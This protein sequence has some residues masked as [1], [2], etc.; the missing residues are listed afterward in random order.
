MVVSPVY[1]AVLSILLWST[2]DVS[3]Q[4]SPLTIGSPS[5]KLAAMKYVRG[6]PVKELS[7]ETI[8]VVEFSGTKCV[9]CIECI[10]HLNE[11]LKK[12]TN[13][14]FISIYGEDEQA[15]R[16]FLAGAGR[17]IALRVAVD[18]GQRMWRGWSEAAC[19]EGVPCVFIVG[20][21]EKIA[22]IGH[23]LNLAEPLARVVAGTFDPQEHVLRLKVEQEAALRLRRARLREEK[24][25]EEY[26]RI[27]GK[28]FDGK[29][30]EALGRHREGSRGVPRL[31]QRDSIV[32]FATRLAVGQLAGKTGGGV[33]AGDG[34]GSRGEDEWAH[35]LP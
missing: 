14:V 35:I 16:G 34:A 9:P 18:P 30:A 4:P 6:D 8:Y 11:L 10:P 13:V 24:G 7:A 29:L 3:P 2:V 27:S 19:Q 21:N 32:P 28:V 1:V 31:P 15:V 22:W 17:G 5:P 26:D 23:P 12:H 25:R 33:P 20:K